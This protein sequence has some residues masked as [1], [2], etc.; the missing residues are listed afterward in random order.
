M[1]QSSGSCEEDIMRHKGA[2]RPSRTKQGVAA[3]ALHIANSRRRATRAAKSNCFLEGI[4]LAWLLA[5]QVRWRIQPVDDV[6][7]MFW[8]IQVASLAFWHNGV[9]RSILKTPSRGLAWPTRHR[10]HSGRHSDI[11]QDMRIARWEPAKVLRAVAGERHRTQQRQYGYRTEI[12]YIHGS[13]NH[14]WM[15]AREPS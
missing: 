7:D 13:P 4:P 2:H 8:K 1:D 9:K 11:W 12:G 6:T 14:E 15:V 3:W 10:L 5:R